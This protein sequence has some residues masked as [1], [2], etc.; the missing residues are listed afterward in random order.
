MA[1]TLQVTRHPG[2]PGAIFL[3][4]IL[5]AVRLERL[6]CTRVLEF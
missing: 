1:I 6:V 4:A 3:Q 5:R 2:D